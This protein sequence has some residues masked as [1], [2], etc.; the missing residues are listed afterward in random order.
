MRERLHELE[1]SVLAADL[2]EKVTSVSAALEA[3]G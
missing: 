2:M 3:S 1:N